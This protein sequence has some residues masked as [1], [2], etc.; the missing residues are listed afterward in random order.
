MTSSHHGHSHSMLPTG[1]ATQ[2]Q[3]N[4]WNFSSAPSQ[5]CA[6]SPYIRSPPGYP[7]SDIC[8]TPMVPPVTLSSLGITN[9]TGTEGLSV[10][11]GYDTP[12]QVDVSNSPAAHTYPTP[13]R[14]TIQ[15]HCSKAW[16]N[17]QN[18]MPLSIPSS[19][20]QS[21]PKSDN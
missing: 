1:G 18:L 14:D 21:S 16:A 3:W 15:N 17:L 20:L 10:S 19:A 13:P 8:E 6:M 5:N 9:I 7:G 4:M 11:Q 12:I 2:G